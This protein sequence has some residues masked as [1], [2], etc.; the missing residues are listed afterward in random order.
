M[1]T[2]LS[3]AILLLLATAG[4][5]SDAPVAPSSPA[6]PPLQQVKFSY[7]RESELDAYLRALARLLPDFQMIID[8]QTVLFD[9]WANG[10]TNAY[11]TRVYA[12]NLILRIR[13][14]GRNA[15]AIRLTN[16]ELIQLNGQL[17]KAMDTLASAIQDFSVAVDP[18]D[19]SI[20]D[21]A[22]QK[23]GQFNVAID[24]YS[25]KLSDL[26]GE[27]ISFF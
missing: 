13:A 21:Q 6:P 11:W 19:D 4:C 16:P 2:K 9:D 8:E 3:C 17:L 7:I 5:G 24:L 20:I 1:K 14:Y 18:P 27:P 22:N 10:R 23:I 26:A 15:A 25:Q 12:N